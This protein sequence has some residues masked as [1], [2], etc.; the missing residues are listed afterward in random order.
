[1]FASTSNPSFSSDADNSSGALAESPAIFDK[2]SLSSGGG[3]GRREASQSLNRIDSPG[4]LTLSASEMF[5]HYARDR[6]QRL[7]KL[8]GIGNSRLRHV[9]LS[10]SAAARNSRN[11]ANQCVS[12]KTLLS[13]II[14]DDAEQ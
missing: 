6:G 3:S 11:I 7:R 4:A 13:Q 12:A 1:M 9:R 10:A 8:A 5:L 2:R 14:S